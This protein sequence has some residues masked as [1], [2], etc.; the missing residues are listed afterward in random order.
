MRRKPIAFM[1]ASILSFSTLFS[2]AAIPAAAAGQA[3]TELE[4]PATDQRASTTISAD[5]EKTATETQPED[6]M[7]PDNAGSQTENQTGADNTMEKTEPTID[8]E[9]RFSARD[10]SKRSSQSKGPY[11]STTYTHAD[12]FDGMTIYNGIDVSYYQGKINWEKVRDAGTDFAFIRAGYRGYST[13]TLVTDN[14]FAANVEGALKA[15]ISVGLYFYTEAVNTKEAIEEANYCLDLAKDYKINFPIVF[16][17]ELTNTA[18]RLVKA[19]LSKSAATA[20]CKAFCETIQAAGYTPMI[21]ANR[22]DLMN[23]I[24]GASLSKSFPIWLAQ[25]ASKPTYTGSYQFWQYT[26]EGKVNGVS[27][28]VDCNFWYSNKAIESEPF[29]R[30]ATAC[31]LKTSNISKVADKTYSGKAFKPSPTVTLDG[32]KLTKGTDYSLSYKNNQEV[33]TATITVKAKGLYTGSKS[34]TFKILPKKMTAIKKKLYSSQIHFTWAQNTSADGYQIFRK[35]TFGEDTA[36]TKIK[37]YKKN[38]KLA[39]KDKNL[40]ED[41]EYYYRFRSFKTVNGKKYYSGYKEFTL[42]TTNQKGK[43]AYAAK[44][45]K[46]YQTPDVTGFLMAK[47]P[48]KASFTYLGRTYLTEDTFFYHVTY[49]QNNVGYTGYLPSDTVINF[50]K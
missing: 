30:T 44:A 4:A 43:T 20:N 24:D 6:P 34:V 9:P 32:K 37:T 7:K 15:G 25:Y 39:Y 49:Y 11:L 27:G 5:S 48:K 14:S 13:G 40:L 45:A 18:G 21:Y 35:N 3:A 36:Y 8:Q 38:T 50:L 19:K 1:M 22:N 10:F 42:S 28:P 26:S 29:A 16:D 33:G 31:S 12:A 46:L 23:K 41:H 2:Q 17:F 47:I